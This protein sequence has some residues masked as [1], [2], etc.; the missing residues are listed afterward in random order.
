VTL[1]VS[2]SA[3][4]ATTISAGAAS[5]D[6]PS[7]T[8]VGITATEIHVA[9]IADVDNPIV[10]N[11]FKG[12]KDA[13]E[14]AAKFLNSKAGGGG[15]AGRKVVVDFYDSKL[16]ANATTNAEIQACQNDVAVVGTSAVSLSSVDEMRNCK[17]STGAVTGL[18][19]IP[20]V[21]TALVQQCSDQSFPMAPPQVICSTAT[22]HPQTFQPNVG[23]AYYY[24][25][26]Y[27]NDLHGIYVFG[28]DSKS[29]RDS[30][31]VSGIG[32]LRVKC[33]KSDQDFDI[34]GFAPQSAYT[35]VIQAMKNDGSNYGQGNQ[36]P[37]QVLLRKEATLQGLTGV[38]VWDCTTGCYS[39]AFLKDGGSDVADNYVDT[40]YLPF[41]STAEQNAN[42]MLKNF[43]KY[44]GV[45]KADGFGVYA[46]SA[47]IAFRDAVNNVVKT[48]GVNGVTRKSIFAAL[49]KI[50]QFNADGMFGTIDLA[51]RKTSPCHVL[52]Q[53]KNGDF[54]RIFPTKVGSFDCAAKNVVEVKL[55]VYGT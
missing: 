7:A 33:C 44:T 1:V 45:D 28:N 19:D 41:L 5:S 22:Q 54:K 36:G 3:L 10:P 46:W 8:D 27:G 31:F 4:A 42:P 40:L 52:M 30:S 9:V 25:K 53:V 2:V 39:K 11:L 55:D 43:V 49:N 14:G 35:P 16:N 18:P 32:Q 50:H 47:M 51:G 12:S 6:K 17:D 13:V 29:A 23:R 20:F 15:L 48:D 34:S 37:Q 26:K 21:S 38:K 24:S